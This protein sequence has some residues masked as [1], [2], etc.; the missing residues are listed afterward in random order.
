MWLWVGSSV[1]CELS[2]QSSG[3]IKGGILIAKQLP[4]SQEL[5]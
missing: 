5:C 4:V 1:E 3:S 2:N